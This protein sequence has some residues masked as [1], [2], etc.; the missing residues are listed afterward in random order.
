[1]GT[2]S[3]GG[4]SGGFGGGGSGSIGGASVTGKKTDSLLDRIVA[5]IGLTKSIN[6][7]PAIAVARKTIAEALQTPVRRRY[8]QEL[9]SDPFVDGVYR[10]LFEISPTLG[11]PADPSRLGLGL[12]LQQSTFTL[13]EVVAALVNRHKSREV[14]ERYVEIT[15]RALTDLFLEAVD[16][17]YRAYS[18]QPARS[19][20]KF[21]HRPFQRLCGHFL[22]SVI[23]EVV[24]RDV[25]GLSQQAQSS[26]QQATREIADRWFEIFESKFHDGKSVRHRDMLHVIAQNY[27]MFSRSE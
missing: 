1:M 25:L 23:R 7:N 11:S 8:L 26:V 22:S 19:I 16:N 18:Q 10:A 9:L 27:S 4:G 3:F 20:A 24:R 21:D 12:G 2:G 5:L 17:D 6:D 14:D 15:R 13:A